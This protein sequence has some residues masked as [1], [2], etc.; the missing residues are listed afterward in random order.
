MNTTN[1]FNDALLISDGACNI[2]GIA[3]TLVKAC[4]EALRAPEFYSLDSDPA[5]K[6]IIS[7]LA[8][9]T[10]I[11]GGVCEFHNDTF[12]ECRALCE[13]RKI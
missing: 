6:L 11:W 3:R 12:S 7:Q 8:Y 13:E 4:D 5:I 1:R 10:G 9:L 2:S